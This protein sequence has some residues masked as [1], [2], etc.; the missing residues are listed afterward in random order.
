MQTTRQN[1]P[2]AAA[3]VEASGRKIPVVLTVEQLK[4]VAGGLPQAHWNVP[5]AVLQLP[6]GGW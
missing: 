4:Q 2:I 3:T 6:Q 1:T 5:A